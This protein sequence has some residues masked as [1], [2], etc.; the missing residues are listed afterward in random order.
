MTSVSSLRE[1]D[2]F[3]TRTR[4]EYEF[5]FSTRLSA[6]ERDSYTCQRCFQHRT[7]VTPKYLEVHHRIPVWF[8]MKY[9]PHLSPLYFRSL[10]CAEC[11]C[12]SC[13][14]LE[15]EE[16]TEQDYCLIA[17]ALLGVNLWSE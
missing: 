3:Q 10:D 5:H 13:H 16:K 4:R 17:V 6:L 9:L 15:H 14:K 2:Q 8:A 7:E 11:L 1:R 12:K